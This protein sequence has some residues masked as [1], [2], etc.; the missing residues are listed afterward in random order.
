MCGYALAQAYLLINNPPLAIC[1]IELDS[2]H[3]K[4]LGPRMALTDEKMPGPTRP[5][6]QPY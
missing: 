4:P 3:V 6:I 5:E 2:E 1:N